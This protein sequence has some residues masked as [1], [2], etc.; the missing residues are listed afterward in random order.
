MHQRLVSLLSLISLLTFSAAVA[1]QDLITVD[2]TSVIADVSRKP[3]GINVNFLL[4]DDD[5]RASRL[6]NLA[7]ALKKAGVRYL[8]YPGGEKSDNYLWAVPP[9]AG[10]VP[11]LARWASGEYPQNQEWPSYDRN[12]V[13]ADGHTFK[14]APLDFDEF[15]AVCRAIDCVP[16]IVVCYDSMYKPAQSG[17]V[18]PTRA[19]LLETAREWVR[20]ANVIKKYNVKYWEIGNESYLPHYNGSATA[21]NYARDLIDFSRVM[22]EVDPTILIGANGESDSWWRTVLST[23][24]GAIDFLAVHN[25]PSTN[26]GSYSYYRNNDVNLM[27]AIQ[28]AQQAINTH[29]PAADRTRLVLASTEISSA[30]WSGGWAHRND[31]GHALVLFDLFGAHL[32]N[33]LVA[34]SQLWNTRWSGNDTATSPALWDALDKHNTLQATGRATAI[35]GQFL[36]EKLVSSSHTAMVRSYSTYSPAT[37]KLTVFLLNKD[38]VARSASVTINGGSA[39]SR[40]DT[41]IFSGEGAHDLAPTW[42]HHGQNWKAGNPISIALA[43]VSVTVLDIT[44][45]VLVHAVPGTIQAEDFRDG[46]YWDS[47]PGNAGGVY[48]ATDVDIQ[49]TSD[50]GGGFN[51]GWISAGE[52]LEYTIHVPKTGYYDFSARVASPYA[53]KS[54]RVLLNGQPLTGSLTVP[55]TGGWQVWQTVTRAAVYLPA[56]THRATVAALTNGFNLN[57]IALSASA[58]LTHAVPGTIQAEDFG[59]TGYWDSTPGNYGNVYRATDVD[60]EVTTDS[61]GGF[62][63]GWIAAGEWLEYA[64]HVHTAGYYDLAAR[65]AS[66]HTGKSF[67]VLVNGTD[68]TG[69]LTVP[70]TGGWQKWQSVTRPGI[71]LPP[72]THRVRMAAVTDGF[73]L[74]WISWTASAGTVHTVPG[75]I[76]AEDFNDG[77]YWDSTA[78]NLGNAYRATDVDIQPT[79]DAGGGF[80]IGWITE[81]EWLEYTIHV[82]TA[83]YYDLAARV[84]SPHTGK[85]FRVLVN[86]GDVTGSVS[87]PNT[88]AHQNWQTVTR[89]RIHF[90]AGTHRLRLVA[91]TGSFNLNWLLL[92]K[93]P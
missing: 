8:R 26:W 3:I 81:G 50:A 1:A 82:A 5:N 14:T 18:A 30:D 68:V 21:S 52:W 71:Y 53:D 57:W 40:V 86:G 2:V 9:Y 12:L 84:A 88:G 66:P 74:N 61:G 83:G 51:V 20:Y 37:G 44:P 24:S 48:R 75:M 87:V 13:E 23:A 46:G 11:T 38:T 16:T 89:P 34:F 77:G 72:G 22:K 32:A 35:W 92:S 4:D 79:S 7:G 70:H 28:I 59:D 67:R 33:P 36:K 93:S 27:G 85:T 90:A 54:F 65:V 69:G 39:N 10:S 60:I 15:M 56:G 76:Q 47:T 41:W 64:V 6:D 49:A 45:E 63:V 17:G 80:N 91:I 31:M 42:V 25:Y 73:N 55:N 62:N 58:E 29:A 43:P 19:Q 78:G